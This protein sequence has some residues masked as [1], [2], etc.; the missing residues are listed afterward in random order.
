LVKAVAVTWVQE[1]VVAIT[2]P[3]RLEGVAEAV[4]ATAVVRCLRIHLAVAAQQSVSF[5]VQTTSQQRPEVVVADIAVMGVQQVVPT[6]SLAQRILQVVE[7][8]LLVE[9]VEF[10]SIAIP[11]WLARSTPEETAATKAVVVAV[12]TGVVVVVA[13]TVVVEVA[14]VMFRY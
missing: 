1:K 4:R 2:R 11:D 5:Q 14:Q 10:R 12:A 6:E 7:L 3:Q 9:R 13:T 8:K